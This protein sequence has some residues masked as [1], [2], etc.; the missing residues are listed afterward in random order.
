MS[1]TMTPRRGGHISRLGSPERGS[2]V[3]GPPPEV[4]SSVVRLVGLPL[5]ILLLILVSASS[6]DEPPDLRT[7][8]ERTGFEETSRYDDVRRVLDDLAASQRR[9]CSSRASA[10]AKRAATF[11]WPCIG[12]P[13]PRDPASARASKKARVLLL[14]NIHAG[15][16]EGKEAA[17][18][19]ARRLAGGDL[20]RLLDRVTVLVAPI[21]NADGNERVSVDNRPAQF[22]PVRRRRHARDGARARSQS[23]LRQA[24]SGRVAGAG[25]VAEHV[26]PARR[27][28]PA[29]HQR[30]LSRLSPDVRLDAGGQRR[31][32]AGAGDAVPA[33]L[34]AAGAGRPRL[35]Q[36]L[37]R[38]LRR[39]RRAR[40]RA[41]P[42]RIGRAG[43]AHVRCAAA[44]RHQR[45][46]PAQPHRD[47]LGGVQLPVVRAP[48][49]GHRDVC[50]DG[51][52]AG[53]AP[54]DGD[55]PR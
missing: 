6:G 43:L 22:G 46:R 31:P 38:Q 33:D 48:G 54:R 25:V 34:G 20:R 45:H 28:R 26:G 39:R 44:V 23:R 2:R 4:N 41:D 37:V 32:A 13:A 55:R 53:G 21:Y 29:H 15:E 7:R 27:H 35:A 1:T 30:L 9:S 12:S 3:Q 52:G 36:L 5:L 10:A 49:P 50:R 47:S 51:A 17:L 11:R 24:G 42:A 19:L 8:A 14:A 40:P 16:V 18:I